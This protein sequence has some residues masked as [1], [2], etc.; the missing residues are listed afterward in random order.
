M[1]EGTRIIVAMGDCGR[2]A[3]ADDTLVAIVEE[4]EKRK[5]S[6]VTVSES[7]CQGYCEYEPIVVVMK[8]DQPQVTYGQVT[9]ERAR[10]IIA[11]HLVSNQVTG[12]W[13]VAVS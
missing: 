8:P 12:E 9:P 5:L 7:S 13:V 11:R 2:A 10:Q 1:N 4:I 3:G 6:D